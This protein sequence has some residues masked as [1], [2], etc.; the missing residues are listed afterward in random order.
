M[1]PRSRGMA[2]ILAWNDLGDAAVTAALLSRWD[3]LLDALRPDLAVCEFA[4]LLRIACWQ[5]LPTLRLG[6]GWSVPPIVGGR[7]P[8]SSRNAPK[9]T[10]SP[11][12]ASMQRPG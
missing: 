1:R 2:D 10:R 6:T 12:C 4:P 5:R 11:C 7:C 8:R 9:P 3:R